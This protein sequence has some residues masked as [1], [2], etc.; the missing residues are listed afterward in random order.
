MF[1]PSVGGI[2]G[3]SDLPGFVLYAVIDKVFLILNKNSFGFINAHSFINTS[4]MCKTERKTGMASPPKEASKAVEEW[5]KAW[6]T[7]V[8]SMI[9]GLWNTLEGEDFLQIKD[10]LSAIKKIIERSVF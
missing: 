1:V 6:I 2:D 5:R 9:A 10:H 8:D 3:F 7:E 4:K